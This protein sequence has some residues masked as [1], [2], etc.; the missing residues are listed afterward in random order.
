MYKSG[1][2]CEITF[3]RLGPLGARER[4]W[5]TSS[6]NIREAVPSS[7]WWVESSNMFGWESAFR[8][9]LWYSDFCFHPMTLIPKLPMSLPVISCI[10]RGGI[11]QDPT[12]Y[13]QDLVEGVNCY[14]NDHVGM[15][16]WSQRIEGKPISILKL[17][18]QCIQM[19]CR[20]WVW[21]E[22]HE[23]GAKEPTSGREFVR[24]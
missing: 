6:D 22:H 11:S 9:F 5:H 8:L 3:C 15:R 16:G 14:S 7:P 17:C 21:Q 23:H 18:C 19:T 13:L 2:Q 20:F 4:P 12:I 10:R 24:K 1:E